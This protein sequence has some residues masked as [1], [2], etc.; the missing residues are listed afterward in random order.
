MIL[1]ENRFVRADDFLACS[2]AREVWHSEQ[3]QRGLRVSECEHERAAG[4]TLPFRFEDEVGGR[5]EGDDEEC[6]AKVAREGSGV[7]V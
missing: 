3:A 5:D 4:L 6:H 7:V 1:L 2:V